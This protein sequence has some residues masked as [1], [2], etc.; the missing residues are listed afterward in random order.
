MPNP[1]KASFNYHIYKRS[2]VNDQGAVLT[3]QG[4]PFIT[5]NERPILCILFVEDDNSAAGPIKFVP[6]PTSD[7]NFLVSID[8]DFSDLTTPM[9]ALGNTYVNT[10]TEWLEGGNANPAAGEMSIHLT[11]AQAEFATRMTA[12]S[13]NGQLQSK[14]EVLIKDNVTNEILFS[15]VSS[16]NCFGLVNSGTPPDPDTPDPAYLTSDM[17]TRTIKGDIDWNTVAVNTYNMPAGFVLEK[18]RLFSKLTTGA[19]LV[20]SDMNFDIKTNTQ[21]IALAEGPLSEPRFYELDNIAIDEDGEILI[22]VTVGSSNSA[23]QGRV[24]FIGYTI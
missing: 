13:S 17:V 2:W 8:T 18:I 6:Y 24:H 19:L 9:M 3:D 21:G 16:I 23:A 11:G 4:L 12:S 5:L 10:D 20:G 14:F 7:V 1:R 15:Y 22:D